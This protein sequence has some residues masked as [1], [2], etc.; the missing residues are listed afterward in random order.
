MTPETRALLRQA[1]AI[2]GQSLS[3]F[4]LINALEEAERTIR[5]HG[6]IVLSE[7][8]SHRFA[9]VVLNP[10]EPNERLRAALRIYRSD[11]TSDV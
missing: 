6:V 3:D 4:V 1:A 10:P 11:T 8:D 9:E 2:R 5:E 7:R